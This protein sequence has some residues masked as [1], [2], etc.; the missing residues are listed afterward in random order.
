M[1]ILSDDECVK[2]I[3]EAM[4]EVKYLTW[5]KQHADFGPADSDV[6]EAMNEQYTRETGC[7][8]PP[9]W[10]LNEEEI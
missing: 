1:K 5:F 10:D 6:H 4:A 9:G 3:D 2:I 8:V 7:P